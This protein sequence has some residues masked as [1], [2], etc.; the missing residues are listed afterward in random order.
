MN[1]R[2]WQWLRPQNAT[3]KEPE[4]WRQA[5]S[6]NPVASGANVT[7]D[8]AASV[9]A[10][11]ACV[12][13]ISES[14][15]TLPCHVYETTSIGKQVA[16]KHPIEPLVYALPNGEQTAV[17]LYEHV[18][19]NVLLRGTAFVELR[20]SSVLGK[21]T[22]MRPLYT[23][24]MRI[25][26]DSQGNLVFDYQEPGNAK[27]YPQES[28]WRIKGLGDDAV[29]GLSPIA[30]GRESIGV[31]LAAEEQAAKLYANGMQTPR[32]FEMDGTLSDE[33]FKR[34]KESISSDYA[35]SSNAFKTLILESGLKLK[36]TGFTPEDSQFLESR[37]FQI[38]EIA[39][40]FRVPLHML[41]ELD[42]ATFSNIE[43]QSIEF[44]RN[45]IRP[46][47]KRL[48]MSMYRDL[49]M[50]QERGRYFV[51]FSIDGLLR[52]DTQSRYDAYGKAIQDGWL[53][54]NEVRLMEDKN[55]VD[56]L[57]EYLIPLNMAK[58]S[59]D[60][61]AAQNHVDREI[62]AVLAEADRRDHE[63]LVAWADDFYTRHA[64]YLIKNGMD[65]Q[66]A[67][68][69]CAGHKGALQLPSVDVGALTDKWRRL[70]ALELAA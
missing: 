7:V 5:L 47:V 59:E 6:V 23:K 24:H 68:T 4:W 17:D 67:C 11:W 41:A 45:T 42:R 15:A 66:T 57:D 56:G 46:W 63:G 61:S 37:K 3:L 32:V 8:T 50:P 38:S 19:S 33:S 25:E 49:L 18:L 39:R 53:S 40:W 62:R 34:L 69:Y 14:I 29:T 54:R 16:T 31:A 30:L 21:L 13:I 2:F 58:S 52:G 64:E 12:R 22:E 27:V 60:L 9:S 55:P 51:K 20:R 36:N 48:E 28:I 65:A 70:A 43:H 44:V 35:G 26:R 1:L 10:V